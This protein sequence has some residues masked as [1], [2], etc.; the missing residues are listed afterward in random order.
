[1]QIPA[2]APPAYGSGIAGV[3]SSKQTTATQEQKGDTVELSPYARAKNLKQ[4]GASNSVIAAQL[5]LDAKTVNSYFG[6]PTVTAATTPQP[7][8]PVQEAVQHTVV[9]ELAATQTK[10]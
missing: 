1:M 10:K 4:Q 9:K 3:N 8:S 6:P 2:N 7:Y 5:G